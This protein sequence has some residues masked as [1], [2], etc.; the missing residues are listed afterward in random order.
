MYFRREYVL[1][2]NQKKA[3][4]KLKSYVKTNLSA[5]LREIENS[6]RKDSLKQLNNFEKALVYKYSDNGY[7]DLNSD[8]RINK[9][10]NTSE[11]GKLLAS[12]VK[13][14]DDFEGLVYRSANL[15]KD[16]LEIY[17]N[18]Y[19][20]NSPITEFSFISTSKSRLIAMQYNG[21]LLFRILSK[22][23]KEIE[24][25][26]KFGSGSQNEREVL[27]APNSDFN[28]LDVTNESSYTLITMEEV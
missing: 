28:V 16:E 2:S 4:D 25:I 6:D 22:T 11:F 10:K 23:G 15:D 7:E 26:S 8:L 20:N 19:K 9:G 12:A 17:L 1:E 5:E 21:N 3:L 13:K 18:A 14:L 24:L 27:F